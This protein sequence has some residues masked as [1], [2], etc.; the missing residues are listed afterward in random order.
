[1]S[2]IKTP[3][4]K[5]KSRGR[6]L[7]WQLILIAA[8]LVLMGLSFSQNVL[9]KT[10]QGN[11][12]ESF[13]ELNLVSHI[14]GDEALSQVDQ[15]HGVGITLVTACIGE[16]ANSTNHFTVWIGQAENDA[17]AAALL[18]LMVNGIADGN[19][20]FSN[21]KRLTVSRGYTDFEIFQVDGPGGSKHFFYLSTENRYGI[22][23]V[24]VDSDELLPVIEEATK[25]F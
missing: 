11:M 20:S 4:P 24:A 19:P 6:S 3:E 7:R 14:D 18:K 23:W 10:A 2:E 15:M 22:V 8:A 9:N 25:T 21:L 17:D 5:K 16:Y 13:A 12:P 1:M